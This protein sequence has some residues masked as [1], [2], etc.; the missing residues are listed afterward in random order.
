MQGKVQKWGN[1][2][3]IRIPRALAKDLELEAGSAVEFA[4]VKG[5]LVMK[6]RP[7]SNPS[8]EDLVA[9]I[10]PENRYAEGSG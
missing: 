4:V 10:S 2:L 5:N 7:E 1:S 9:K 8:L 3:A 6:P